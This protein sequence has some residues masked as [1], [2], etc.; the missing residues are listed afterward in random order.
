MYAC[1]CGM[2]TTVGVRLCDMCGMIATVLIQ[3]II[4]LA[5]Q[6]LMQYRM[7]SRAA[8]VYYVRVCVFVACVCAT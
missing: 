8:A 1:V 3:S 6:L 4:I 5:L 2:I 7:H